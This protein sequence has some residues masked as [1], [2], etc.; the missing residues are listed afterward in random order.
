MEWGRETYRQMALN[1]ITNG[2]RKWKMFA[3]PSAK[4]RMMHSTPIHCP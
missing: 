4:Q 1:M 3:I 2:C